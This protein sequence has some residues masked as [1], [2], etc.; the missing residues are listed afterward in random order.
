LHGDTTCANP[1]TLG[2]LVIWRCNN[3]VWEYAKVVTYQ[4]EDGRVGTIDPPTWISTNKPC[5]G[6]PPVE[7]VEAR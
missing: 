4:C 1:Q 6:K 2:E 7:K 5:G 3:Q